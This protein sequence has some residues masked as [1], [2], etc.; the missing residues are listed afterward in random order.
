MEVKST[1][2]IIQQIGPQIT[3]RNSN[4]RE[5]QP[6]NIA[7]ETITTNHI[8]AIAQTVNHLLMPLNPINLVKENILHRSVH[9]HQLITSERNTNPP[10]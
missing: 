5:I 6:I 1:P 9:A 4:K 3:I 7:L 2:R 10:E 8:L